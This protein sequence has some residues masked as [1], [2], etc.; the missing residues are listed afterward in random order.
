M[1]LLA[2]IFGLVYIGYGVSIR[3]QEGLNEIIVKDLKE[4][5]ANFKPTDTNQQPLYPDSS[6]EAIAE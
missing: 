3:K 1:G 2:V 5:S 4:H 6:S